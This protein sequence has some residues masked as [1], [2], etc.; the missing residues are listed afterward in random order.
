MKIIMYDDTQ[1]SE[2]NF[3]RNVISESDLKK[4]IV[5]GKQFKLIILGSYRN[6]VIY[7]EMYI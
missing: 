7:G 2:S 4:V 3:W 6:V 1:L 5:L